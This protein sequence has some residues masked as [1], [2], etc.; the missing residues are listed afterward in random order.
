MDGYEQNHP[1]SVRLRVAVVIFLCV[2]KGASMSGSADID[3]DFFEQSL[4]R[5]SAQF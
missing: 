5:E 1:S 2:C 4:F 3:A